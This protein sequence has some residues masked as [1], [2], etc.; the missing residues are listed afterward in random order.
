M[1]YLEVGKIITTHGIKGE[2][3]V[4]LSTSF[5]YER[6]E[7][8]NVLYINDNNKYIPITIDTFRIHKGLGLVSFNGIT[9]INDCLCYVGKTIY[10]DK[11]T[12]DEL[13]E[14]NFYFDDLIG[15]IAYT[16]N[17]E[18]IGEVTDILDVPQ[19]AILIINN[20]KKEVLVPFVDEFIKEVLL[21]E[22]KIIITPIE[23]LL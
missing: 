8:G 16:D 9:N 23:G 21:D 13:E 10:V 17:L 3:K 4:S 2:V 15:L 7:K 1:K 11:E 12:L 18:K 19:G 22:N 14:D 6:F 20:G 5:P